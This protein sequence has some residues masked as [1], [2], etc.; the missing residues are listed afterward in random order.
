MELQALTD[1]IKKL[2]AEKKQLQQQVK[3]LQAELERLMH[4]IKGEAQ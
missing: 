4:F 2:E 1:K 3:M